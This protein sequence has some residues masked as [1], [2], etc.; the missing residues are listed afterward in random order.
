MLR[1]I[2][3]LLLSTFCLAAVAGD[4][5]DP[6]LWLEDV[7]SEPALNWVRQQNALTFEELK[8]H[9]VFEALYDEAY[10]IL[11]ADSRIPDGQIVG[12]DFHSFWQDE[13]HV[14]GVWR[15]TS[16]ESLINGQPEWRLLKHR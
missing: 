15:A 14:R 2:S 16:L 9:S 7:E 11:T 13:T 8:R 1:F 3:S 6:Y 10:S 12:D 5:D 4:I